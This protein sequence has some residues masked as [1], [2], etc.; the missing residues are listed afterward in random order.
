MHHDHIFT[1]F[2]AMPGVEFL[3]RLTCIKQVSTQMS[4]LI[5]ECQQVCRNVAQLV[6][7]ETFLPAS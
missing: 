1:A 5:R 3:L 2:M 4:C 7:Q 6:S